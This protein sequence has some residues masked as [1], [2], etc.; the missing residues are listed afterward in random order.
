[1]QYTT[2]YLSTMGEIL[3]ACDDTGLTGLWFKGAK[4]YARGLDAEHSESD[5]P[6]FRNT[7]RWLDLYFSGKNPDFT[8]S[9]HMI[10]SP[11]YIDVWNILLTIPYGKTTTYGKIAKTLAEKRGLTGMSAQAVGGAVAHNPISLI[12]PCHR[13]IGSNKSLTGYAG[14]RDKK[15]KLLTLEGADGFFPDTP[16]IIEKT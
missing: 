7:R 8:P 4:Y 16:K 13:V 11:F 6:V 10:G 9:I 3:L 2:T 5:H 14:G 15:A 12:I 1:M